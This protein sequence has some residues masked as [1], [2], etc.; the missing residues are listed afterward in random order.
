VAMDTHGRGGNSYMNA[1]R[2][3]AE[4]YAARA[5][6]GFDFIIGMWE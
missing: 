5:Y 6:V 1:T 4:L 3:G 2:Y